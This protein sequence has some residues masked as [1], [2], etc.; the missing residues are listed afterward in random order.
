MESALISKDFHFSFSDDLRGISVHLP[1][2]FDHV[3]RDSMFLSNVGKLLPEYTA[4]HLRKF[5]PGVKFLRRCTI[6]III[7][8]TPWL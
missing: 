5:L 4:S 2:L 7:I 6:I 3:D 1:S 8:I